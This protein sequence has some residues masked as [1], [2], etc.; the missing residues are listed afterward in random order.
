MPRDIKAVQA[1]E[2]AIPVHTLRHEAIGL[3]L[4]FVDKRR[5][6]SIGQL[7]HLD[8][9]TVPI[10]AGLIATG[11][12]IRFVS[13]VVPTAFVAGSTRGLVTTVLTACL[14][15]VRVPVFAGGALGG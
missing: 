12:R 11:L 14:V 8:R 7:H 4:A 13:C 9:S 1:V 5:A 3:C 10:C 6:P 2:I 15:G